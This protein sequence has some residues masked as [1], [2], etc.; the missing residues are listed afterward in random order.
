ME[1]VYLLVPLTLLLVA[2][3]IG[4]FSWAVKNGQYDDLDGPAH[5][6]LYD[7]DEDMIPPGARAN[8]NDAA[9]TE[10]PTPSDNPEDP[11]RR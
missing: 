10:S 2:V 9:E 7:D 8:T 5:Q 4:I 11:P 6:I 3:G 1:I